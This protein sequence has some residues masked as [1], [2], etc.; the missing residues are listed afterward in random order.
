MRGLPLDP[1]RA[2]ARCRLAMS[3]EMLASP[4]SPPKVR[5]VP[6]YRGASDAVIVH[7]MRLRIAL[8]CLALMACGGNDD[9]ESGDTGTQGTCSL[10]TDVSGGTS[11]RFTGKSDAVCLTQHSFDTG[12]DALFSGL[13]GKGTFELTIDDIAEGETGDDYAVQI[14]VTNADRE[15]WQGMGCVA[16]ITAH[17][18]V[19]VEASEIGELRHYQVAGEGSC[20][21]ALE[22]VPVGSD[23][24]TVGPFGFRAQ[25]TWRD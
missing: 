23:S 10:R 12:I 25:I 13:N 1:A 20:W 14:V 11:L 8:L 15:R 7:W 21:D 5:P 18:L 6:T 17:D 19:E 24:V 2:T 22:S 4:L 16:S 3:A 9:D